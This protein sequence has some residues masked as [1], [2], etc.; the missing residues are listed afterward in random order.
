MKR[1][2]HVLVLVLGLGAT[3]LAVLNFP[4]QA[5]GGPIPTCNP[6]CGCKPACGGRFAPDGTEPFP[7][8]PPKR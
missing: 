2:L 8:R 1:Y 7:K 4:A 6:K 3:Y 5:D